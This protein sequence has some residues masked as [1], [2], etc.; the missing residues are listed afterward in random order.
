MMSHLDVDDK[1]GE[2]SASNWSLIVFLCLTICLF[3]NAFVSSRLPLTVLNMS[4]HRMLSLHVHASQLL[5]VSG[6]RGTSTCTCTHQHDTQAT[7]SFW[8]DWRSCPYRLLIKTTLP[9]ALYP[10][11][12]EALGADSGEWHAHLGSLVLRALRRVC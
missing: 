4:A 2:V 6:R 12:L 3:L 9:G 11:H 7:S 5:S 1:Q 10:H 8:A